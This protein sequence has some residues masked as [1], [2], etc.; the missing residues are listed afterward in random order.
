MSGW[1]S[2]SLSRRKFVG[3][4]LAVAAGVAAAGMVGPGALMPGGFLNPTESAEAARTRRWGVWQPGAPWDINNLASVESA[5]GKK[6]GIVHW[7]QGWGAGNKAVDIPLIEQVASYGAWPVI[8]WEPWDYTKGMSQPE[9]ALRR[10]IAGNFD[11]YVRG[12][13]RELKAYGGKVLLRFAHEMNHL[14]YPWSVGTNGNT[15]AEY[16]RAWRRVHGIFRQEGA[17]NVKFIWCPNVSYAGTTPFQDVYP[18]AEY[19][20]WIGLDG[21]N[22]GSGLDWGGWLSFT[23]VFKPSYDQLRGYARPM[24]VCEVGC[25]ESG[26]DKGRWITDAFASEIPNAM[27]RLSAVIWFNENREVDWRIQSS[28]RAS[29]AFR[30]AVSAW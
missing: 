11:D 19:V 25:A 15:A 3:T 21:Y 17:T 8:T 24:M 18:G 10:I 20:D 27:P 29:R 28:Q 5:A 16:V 4:G 6:P 9:Y 26:G 13:A 22:G 23:Q 12:W 1:S 14:R 2:Q 7:Y 30:D